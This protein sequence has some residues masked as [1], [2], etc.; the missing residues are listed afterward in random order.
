ME[1][2]ILEVFIKCF[3]KFVD[4]FVKKNIKLTSR[5]QILENILSKL[6]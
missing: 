2:R 4:L 5:W 3:L 1:I 6:F